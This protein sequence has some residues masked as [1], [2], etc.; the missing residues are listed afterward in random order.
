[1]EFIQIHFVSATFLRKYRGQGFKLFQ[2]TRIQFPSWLFPSIIYWS[3]KKTVDLE[4]IMTA[5]AHSVVLC[6]ER[7][8]TRGS[9]HFLG[10]VVQVSK[11]RVK[12]IEL[13]Y[14]AVMNIVKH[15][16]QALIISFMSVCNDK[17][18]CLMTGP[19]WL[20]LLSIVRVSFFWSKSNVSLRTQSYS[21]L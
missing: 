7:I 8:G 18:S 19:R 4:W 11:D 20:T 16:S 14:E 17:F 3:S 9:N 1:M 2:A 15:V 10:K 5:T 13:F 12:R 21:E 6:I